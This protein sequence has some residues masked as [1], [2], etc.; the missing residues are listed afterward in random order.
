[1]DE[2]ARRS[3]EKFTEEMKLQEELEYQELKRLL[4][5]HAEENKLNTAVVLGCF[6]ILG[7]ILV[8][9]F[10]CRR[11]QSGSGYQTRMGY[12][13]IQIPRNEQC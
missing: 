12:E 5:I 8:S 13:P 9:I 11:I 4:F 3:W 7:C 6:I 1:M 10:N 2:D